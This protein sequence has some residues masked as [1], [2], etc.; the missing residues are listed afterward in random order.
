MTGLARCKPRAATSRANFT[1]L[2]GLG[3]VNRP[4][5]R[6]DTRKKC[7]ASHY[8]TAAARA[9]EQTKQASRLRVPWGNR[10]PLRELTRSV[11]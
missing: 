2:V 4:R 1:A 10:E 8:I 3:G 7:A 5:F 11:C 9:C 6:S